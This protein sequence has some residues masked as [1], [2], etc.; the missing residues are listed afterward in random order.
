MFF[1]CAL[2]KFANGSLHPFQVGGELFSDHDVSRFDQES[3]KRRM[4]NRK[5]YACFQLKYVDFFFEG[6]PPTSRRRRFIIAICSTKRVARKFD[7]AT[8]WALGWH[9]GEGI[10]CLST[11]R[12]CCV[13][14]HLKSFLRA[15]RQ[16]LFIRLP[17]AFVL[18]RAFMR[19][20]RP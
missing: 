13:F 20:T 12:A 9:V 19:G 18:L 14:F 15:Q 3:R 10:V 5:R 6:K 11:R 17:S 4:I 1:A 7:A 8:R 16:A 2:I